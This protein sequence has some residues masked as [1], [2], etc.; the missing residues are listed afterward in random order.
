MQTLRAAPPAMLVL[1]LVALL[2]IRDIVV[3]RAGDDGRTGRVV[4]IGDVHGDIEA[5][6]GI[7]KRTELLDE[8]GRW[9][10]GRTTLVQTGDYTDRGEKVR[11][12]L[13]LLMRLEK[14]AAVAG[15]RSITLLG[16]HEAMN[17]IGELRDVT[18]QIFA[19]FAD[20]KSEERRA[21]AWEAYVKI[22]QQR[23]AAGV[24]GVP[25]YEVK[26]REEWDLKHPPGYFEFVEAMGPQGRYGRWLR[27]RPAAVQIGD[28]ILLH[29]GIMPALAPKKIDDLN[30]AVRRELRTFDEIRKVL[31][32]RRLALPWFSFQE[33]REAAIAELNAFGQA[34][35]SSNGSGVAPTLSVPELRTIEP[36][37]RVGTW[38]LINPNG[39]LWFRGYATWTS[40]EGA[41]AIGPLLERYKA[42]RIVVG[43]T[44]VA[45]M[46]ITPRFSSRVFL[47]DTGM[48]AS[49]YK[50]RASALEI[51][52]ND[53]SAIYMDSRVALTAPASAPP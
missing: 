1:A 26:A 16:N 25:V 23:K 49:H 5:F 10:G 50:G 4:A 29:G 2:P 34:Q 9:S 22:A 42:R 36:I 14:E 48:L 51:E 24:S 8:Q 6:L 37:T 11:D 7:L 40:E 44:I 18:P 53:V 41:A 12:V 47:I 32:D 3:A 27:A 43:H 39:P 15:G 52:G 21:A 45:S 13:D 46:R 35:E 33:I 30:D 38:S 31:V 20:E 19:T 28:T 17:L